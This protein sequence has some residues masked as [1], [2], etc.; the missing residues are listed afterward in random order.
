[1]GPF[2]AAKFVRPV[3]TQ[4][5]SLTGIQ[6]QHQNLAPS[7]IAP[8]RTGH[9]ELAAARARARCCTACFWA[10]KFSSPRREAEVFRGLDVGSV[11]T[12]V[13]F[14]PGPLYAFSR[15]DIGTN[16]TIVLAALFSVFAFRTKNHQTTGNWPLLGAPNLRVWA[17]TA[18][19]Q[20]CL[21][22]KLCLYIDMFVFFSRPRW[23]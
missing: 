20:T 5:P 15:L 16:E 7:R 8:C 18:V 3:S 17:G 9:L 22:Q 21:Q 23:L 13:F 4:P 12:F 14:L 10:R 6:C 1:M 19:S 11:R 2:L